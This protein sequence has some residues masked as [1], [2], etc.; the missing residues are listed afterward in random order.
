MTGSLWQRWEWQGQRPA[1]GEECLAAA[2][3]QTR[4]A[5]EE[6][7]K[8]WGCRHPV[9]AV[10]G[11]GPAQTE[12]LEDGVAVEVGRGAGRGIREVPTE[13]S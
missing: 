10:L 5:E 13:F 2:M 6:E 3:T 1:D 8:Q 4:V 12:R 11:E 7:K 9:F